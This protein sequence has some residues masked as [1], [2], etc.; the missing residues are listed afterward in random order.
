M[1]DRVSI[2]W[3]KRL[4]KSDIRAW[5][6]S[7]SSPLRGGSQRELQ[8]GSI[9]TVFQDGL[10]SGNMAR[11]SMAFLGRGNKP[12]PGAAGE[13]HSDNP[14]YVCQWSECITR[15]WSDRARYRS[16]ETS[17]LRRVWKFEGNDLHIHGTV[18]HRPDDKKVAAYSTEN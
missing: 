4:R 7:R 8:Q 18:V 6:P 3:R 12:V 5:M 15:G 10:I 9:S 16:A 14:A 13:Y 2:W 17:V 11:N 1:S